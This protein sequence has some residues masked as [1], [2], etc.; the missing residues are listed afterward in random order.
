MEVHRQ[1]LILL[2][3]IHVEWAHV[4]K[5][6]YIFM[7]LPRLQLIMLLDAVHVELARIMNELQMQTRRRLKKM[8]V[9]RVH[10]H[11]HMKYQHA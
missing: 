4:L 7:V 5:M 1:L 3:I 11:C 9:P 10:C 6:Q 2:D 8:S